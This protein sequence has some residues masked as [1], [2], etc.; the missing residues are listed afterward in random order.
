MK[1]ARGHRLHGFTLIELVVV[2]AIIG[3]L[4][5]IALP[6]YLRSIDRG[7]AQVQRQNIAVMRDAIDKFFGDNGQ[8]PENLDELVQ[9][10]YLRSVPEDPVSGGTDWTVIASPDADK[11]GV[12][13]VA[14]A[15][16]A[17]AA[18]AVAVVQGK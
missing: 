7:K 13:D 11:A 3:L 8:Y 12:Y 5:T 6:R 18:P 10:H 16:E 1:P 2:M 14:P 9:K 4:L 17:A 15:S